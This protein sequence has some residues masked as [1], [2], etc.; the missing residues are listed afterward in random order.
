MPIIGVLAVIIENGR[1]LLT[2]RDDFAVW[3]LPSGALEDDDSLE[4]A[5]AHEVSEETGLQVRLAREIV[6]EIHA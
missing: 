2:Q 1:I 5:A 6:G 3:C 4:E